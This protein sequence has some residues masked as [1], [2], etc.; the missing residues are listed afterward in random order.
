MEEADAPSMAVDDGLEGKEEALKVVTLGFSS[1]LPKVLPSVE[2]IH[3][4]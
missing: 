2:D 3:N 1:E 4:P